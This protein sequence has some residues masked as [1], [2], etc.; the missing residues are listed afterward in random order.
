MRPYD[1]KDFRDIFQST[2]DADDPVMYITAEQRM[3]EK[4]GL[5]LND[6]MARLHKAVDFFR[7]GLRRE[8]EEIVERNQFDRESK[9]DEYHYF[10][11]HEGNEV[12]FEQFQAQEEE[13]RKNKLAEEVELAIKFDLFSKGIFNA[14]EK[15]Q[16]SENENENNKDI[17]RADV[18]I[19]K[20]ELELYFTSVFRGMGKDNFN[21]FEGFVQEINN[22]KA[23]NATAKDFAQVA[24]MCYES[25]RMNDRKPRTFS[26]WYELFCD[27][28]GCE[29]IPSYGKNKLK[30]IPEKLK[31]RFIFLQ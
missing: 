30:N 22:L 3:A 1:D 13:R 29:H 21:Y 20:S 8:R 15:S 26:K 10:E 24:F 27:L 17:H 28:T 14:L 23:E 2:I 31:N 6:F 11:W 9:I 18:N 12:S 19:N 16:Q 25:R 4:S 7:S 5:T